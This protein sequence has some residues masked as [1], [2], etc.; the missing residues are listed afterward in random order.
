MVRITISKLELDELA[1]YCR[2]AVIDRLIDVFYLRNTNVQSI[3]SPIFVTEKNMCSQ[4]FSRH[5]DH[6]FAVLGFDFRSFS[7]LA[8]QTECQLGS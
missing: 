6:M 7:T 4:Y 5:P 1:L 2:A 3:M 8:L